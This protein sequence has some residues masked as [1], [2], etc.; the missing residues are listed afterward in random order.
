MNFPEERVLE[1]AAFGQGRVPTRFH[2]MLLP[3]WQVEIGADVTESGSL[4]SPPS[5]DVPGT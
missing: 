4:R 3:V 1:D 5:R 2:A